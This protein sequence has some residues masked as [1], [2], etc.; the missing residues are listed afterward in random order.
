[1]PRPMHGQHPLSV[2]SR[3][4]RSISLMFGDNARMTAYESSTIAAIATPP[5]S[6]GIGVVRVSGPVAAAVAHALLGRLPQPRLAT[7]GRFRDANG[8]SL[9][10][11]LALWFPGPNSYTGEDVLEL[12]GHG[13]P[14]ALQLL[15]SAALAAGARL[16]QPGE[17]TQRAYLNGR[18]D[19][20]QAEAVA[21]LIAAG[22][23]AAARAAVRSL[24]GEFSDRVNA[25][26]MGLL[27]TR[28]LCE[29]SLDFPDERD[30]PVAVELAG[31]LASLEQACRALL[32]ATRHGV[33]HSQAP[34][35]VL[36]GRPNAGKS[37]LLN[38]LTHEDT[39]IVTPV[40][41]TT[42]DVLQVEVELAGVGLT[43]LDTAGLRDTVDVVEQEGVRR[44]R[45]AVV[46][47]DL[48]L[49][50]VDSA[51]NEA[52]AAAADDIQAMNLDE[53]PGQNAA[54]ER[55]LL[56]ASKTDLAGAGANDA[57]L[58]PDALRVSTATG[59][60]LDALRTE[61]LRRLGR[62]SG[63]GV[64]AF[65]ARE[66]HVQAVREALHYLE[67]ARAADNAKAGGELVAEELRLAQDALGAIT[68]RTVP[69]DVLAEVFGRFCIGK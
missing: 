40:P 7:L 1:M 62:G 47:A 8:A 59:E 31:P 58:L 25:L 56:V 33:R 48:V 54:T 53:L 22:S 63:E 19:L 27:Q 20:A 67:A 17:F 61:I 30:V 34:R 32:E 64:G 9:D 16:A 29:A 13:S 52:L 45:A 26:A 23:A 46:N 69:D 6:G 39:A 36:A 35:V 21:D 49:Y 50:L 5:G 68:G 57:A 10:E 41:G 2:A 15:L 44:A 55:L 12:Q 28:A 24:S 60:G 65:S 38:A 4:R 14:A 11:G 51:D 66:R 18:M 42:R 37:S 3:G 43:L